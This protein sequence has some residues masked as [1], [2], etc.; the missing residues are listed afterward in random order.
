MTPHNRQRATLNADGRGVFA[1]GSTT[2]TAVSTRP[3]SQARQTLRDEAASRR[4]SFRSGREIQLA[5]GQK[6]TIP[7]PPRKSEA[8]APSLG[9]AYTDI[10]QAILEAQDG[11]E[12]L[13]SELAFAIYLLEQNYH[14]SPADYRALL[15]SRGSSDWQ[16]SF[17]QIAEE[18]LHAFLDFSYDETPN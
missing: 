17:H 11:S 15:A 14:L 16:P 10:I 13:R 7:D 1:S 18:H 3:M 5:D 8:P 4:A 2:M 6:W 12:Q 9:T